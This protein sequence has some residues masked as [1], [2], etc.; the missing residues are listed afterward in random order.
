[1]SVSSTVSW[2]LWPPNMGPC[3]CNEEHVGV[4]LKYSRE[5]LGTG[6]RLAGG[7]VWG[8]NKRPRSFSGG[9]GVIA[10]LGAKD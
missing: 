4:L 3:V 1:M 7:G 5:E 9:L 10:G 8:H 2:F 6:R